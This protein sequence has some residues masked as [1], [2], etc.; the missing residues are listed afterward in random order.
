[1]T[2]LRIEVHL[3]KKCEDSAKINKTIVA[4]N[5]RFHFH[6]VIRHT[7]IGKEVVAVYLP[8]PKEKE[9]DTKPYVGGADPFT[10]G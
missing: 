5:R 2:P 4:F 10:G 7:V 6:G 8:E 1:M 3:A 9:R